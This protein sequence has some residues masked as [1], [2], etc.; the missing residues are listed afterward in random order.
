M[1]YAAKVDEET[2]QRGDVTGLLE[3][4][5]DVEPDGRQLT[6]AEVVSCLFALITAGAETTKALIG[7]TLLAWQHPHSWRQVEDDPA[8]SADS[9]TRPA[10][11]NHPPAQGA[12]PTARSQDAIA[13]ETDPAHRDSRWFDD[14]PIPSP[15]R[16]TNE[17]A[18]HATPVPSTV[19]ATCSPALKLKPPSVFSLPQSAAS[20]RATPIQHAVRPISRAVADLPFILDREGAPEVHRESCGFHGVICGRGT[21]RSFAVAEVIEDPRKRQ[22]LLWAHASEWLITPNDGRGR[23]RVDH[24]GGP[25]VQDH[26]L[27][28][29]GGHPRL[30]T[31]PHL[32]L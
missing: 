19:C 32:G 7:N 22:H 8:S 27:E 17:P 5:L 28:R 9:S 21:D 1:A 20:N 30:R 10:S 12:F 31:F 3:H 4:L 6:N 23:T 14:P 18:S 2:G 25:N 11:G 26:G 15:S 16:A 24:R 13:G 29:R